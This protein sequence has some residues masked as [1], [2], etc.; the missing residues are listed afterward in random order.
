MFSPGKAWEP[1]SRGTILLDDQPDRRATPAFEQNCARAAAITTI[2]YHRDQQDSDRAL[3]G[4]SYEENN[5]IF[6]RP[7]GA[8][9]RPDQMSA[10]VTALAR[11]SGLPGIGLHSLR[12]SHASQLIGSGTPITVIADR[13]G[14]ANSAVTLSIY[15]HALPADVNAAAENWNTAMAN[16]IQTE[17]KNRPARMLVNVSGK[18]PLKTQVTERKTG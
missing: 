14:H 15:S 5:L 2:E 18:H 11:K 8:Y 9:Y 6:C 13:L 3:Y 16:T 12:H 1:N 10:R 4:A 17:R 7:D